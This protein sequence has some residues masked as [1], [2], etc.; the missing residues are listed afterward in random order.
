MKGFIHQEWRLIQRERS[1]WILLAVFIVI[2]LYAIYNGREAIEKEKHALAHD[3]HQ[4]RAF[5][6]SLEQVAKKEEAKL[7]S[8]QKPLEP[9][10]WGA[11]HP[12]FANFRAAAQATLPVLNLSA[13]SI[14]QSDLY[15]K[16]RL[17]RLDSEQEA[18]EQDESDLRNPLKLKLGEFDFAFVIVYLFPLLIIALLFSVMSSEKESGVLT[19]LGVQP[20]SLFEIAR[21]KL[22]IRAVIL[23]GVAEVLALIGVLWSGATLEANAMRVGLLMLAVLVYGLFW[24]ALVWFVLSFGKSPAVNALSLGACWIAL[25]VV[26]PSVLNGVAEMLYP[27][28][29]RVKYVDAMRAASEDAERRSAKLLEQ[30][31]QAHPELAKDTLARDRDFAIKNLL[32]M[33]DVL[34]SIQ[35]VRE[36]F[37][38]QR[39]RQA[40]FV[41]RVQ[42]LSPAIVMQQ[43]LNT[44][45]GTSQERYD[46]FMQEARA[47]HQKWRQLFEPL[48]F[49]RKAFT[50][51]TELPEFHFQEEDNAEVAT[52][53]LVMLMLI[54]IP[55]SLLTVLAYSR[56]KTYS[57]V[58]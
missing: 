54:L 49:Q 46:K 11:R 58:Q 55:A 31:Y 48:I 7:V 10:A 17:I 12:Y 29:S 13:L 27:L 34:K 9:P 20:M 50:N 53:T 28:P 36:N 2:A 3:A 30:F 32:A 4:R 6:D 38:A 41:K 47:F 5:L 22:L 24:V 23:L 39:L 44:I 56:F 37:H 18:F 43:T 8:L 16:E 35:P 1:L 40:E 33:E 57:I 21:T 45:V 26:L 42:W 19:L 15:I 25:L 52:R 51:Y 14:G